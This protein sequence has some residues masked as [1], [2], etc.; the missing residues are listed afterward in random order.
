VAGRPLA[1]IGLLRTAA[2]S[3]Y[4]ASLSG[5]KRERVR[6]KGALREKYNEAKSTIERT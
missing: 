3:A 6:G 5:R 4:L 2:P 1:N